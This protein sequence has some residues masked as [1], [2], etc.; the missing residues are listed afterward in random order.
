MLSRGD[1]ILLRGPSRDG[2]VGICKA[3]TRTCRPDGSG[4]NPC[5]EQVQPRT[6]ICDTPEDEDCD[7]ASQSEFPG[8]CAPGAIVGCY[9]GPPATRWVGICK[10]GTKVCNADGTAYSACMGEVLPAIEA[11]RP[12]STTTATAASPMESW[13]AAKRATRGTATMAPGTMGVG[14]CQGGTQVCMGNGMGFGPCTGQVIPQA[15][16]CN[17]PLDESCNGS[18]ACTGA[19]LWSKRYGSKTQTGTAAVDKSGNIAVIGSFDETTD[20]GGGLLTSAGA[21]MSTWPS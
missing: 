3:G 5:T 2:G 10:P 6:E 11:A 21:P 18:G 8:C 17:T 14:I 12:L 4:F 7:G 13:T 16:Q 19:Y 9:S 20:L 15:E 1:R